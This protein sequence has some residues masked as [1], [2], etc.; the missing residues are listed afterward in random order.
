MSIILLDANFLAI[1][2]SDSAR[3]PPDPITKQP[4]NRAR[5][6]VEFL[7]EQLQASN[8]KILIPTPALSEF[9]IFAHPDGSRYL[10]EIHGLY[11]FQIEEFDEMAA[12]ELAELSAKE[13]KPS[14]LKRGEQTWAKLK[15]DRQIVAM[16]LARN[17]TALYSTDKDLRELAKRH[18]IEAFNL[19]DT[20]LP[21]PKQNDLFVPKVIGIEDAKQQTKSEAPDEKSGSKQIAE[22]PPT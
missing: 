15:F 8:S 5:D 22:P 17:V 14:K 19:G 10:S 16:A 2:L 9:L 12:I 6:R 7:I 20:P 13:I 4:Y 21:P 18:N 11:R 1:L 3:I